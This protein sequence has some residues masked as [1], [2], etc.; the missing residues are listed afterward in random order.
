MR[1]R[2]IPHLAYTLA[3]SSALSSALA[4]QSSGITSGDLKG[5]VRIQGA[6][7]PLTSAVLTLVDPQTR[8]TRT[9]KTGQG[10]EYGFW[11]VPPGRYELTIEARGF[12]T[13]RFQN[14]EIHLRSVVVQDVELQREAEAYVEVVA[15]RAG[16]DPS[17]TQVATVIEPRYIEELP[18]DRRS[19][20]DF[21]LTVPGVII[22]NTPVNG[23]TPN[24]G[25]SIR[26]MNPRQNS[27]L[28]DGLD[29]NDRGMGAPRTALS[30]DAVQ[31]FQVVTAGFSAEFG[32][33]AGGVVNSITRSGTNNLAGSAFCYWRPGQMDA[34]SPQ[35]T[36][37]SDYRQRQFGA[38]VGGPLIPDK[39]FYLISAE[40]YRK[41]DLN[42]VVIPDRA[43][44]AIR[45]A[46][47]QVDG[48]GQTFEERQS[49]AFIRL[50]FLQSDASKW[51]LRLL[52]ARTKNENQIPWGGLT[53][54][55]AGG[56]VDLRD[57]TWMLSHQWLGEGSWI[58]EARFMY[59]S[60]DRSL[61]SMDAAH[62]VFVDI[63]GTAQFGTQRL[64]PQDT[65]AVYRQFTDT[66][67]QV[68]ERHTL[69]SGIDLLHSRNRGSVAQN[70]AG[71]Y[72]FTAIP[73]MGLPTSLD[74]FAAGVPAAFV[75]SFGNPSTSFQ[76]DSDAVFLQDD[77]QVRPSV[78]LK[79]GLRYDR[80]ILPTYDDAPAYQA[81]NTPPNSSDPVYGPTRLPDGEH[82][83]SQLYAVDRDWSR[84]RLSPRMAFS[85]QA[86]DD[87]RAYGGYGVYSGSTN[88]GALFGARLFN[89]QQVQTLFRTAYDPASEQPWISWANANNN[90]R[91]GQPPL[92]YR[93]TIVIPG[94]YGMPASRVWNLGL[95]WLPAQ[96]H[97]LYLDL[98]YSRGRGFMNTREVN[99][100]VPYYSP[101]LG[102][103]IPRRP[104]LRFGSIQRIDG[105]G[106]CRYRGQ[107]LG[108]QWRQEETWTLDLSYTH[109]QAEDNYSDWTTDYRVQNSF[110]PGSEWGP[111]SEDQTHQVLL[112]VA[113]A[114]PKTANHFWQNWVVSAIARYAS[115]RPYTRLLGY[116]ANLNGDG[117]SD[118]PSGVG[119][120]RE[121]TPDTC[122]VDLRLGRTCPFGR[123]R[124]EFLMEVFNLFN[125]SNVLEVQ[126][127]LGSTAPPYGTPLRYGGMRKFQVGVRMTF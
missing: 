91:Y 55:S 75:Q 28:L 38:R 101:A 16:L 59:A 107:T 120:N 82:P 25:L 44:G 11:M 114:S 51:G 56:T 9:R 58:N 115:G 30:Q 64:T 69:K 13:R 15:E 100:Y 103:V 87:V 94:S 73:Q 68:M 95:E 43:L 4:A 46:G 31:E 85:W 50:D 3:L 118:R 49:T 26:G 92:G 37:D 88:L 54:R 122:N 102:T 39:L 20:I 112:C 72:Q 47:F 104:D 96:G 79:L 2:T 7:E 22:S 77:W 90:H 19:F 23:G 98:V 127:N 74:A 1:S 57:T 99:A 110:D 53:A 21:S 84:S 93:P 106:E 14:L 60:R 81:L 78:L 40:G 61:Q 117:T 18:I 111:S 97:R 124:A 24:S 83:Y 36:E 12:L 108:W 76:A 65:G 71:I 63:L 52:E 109:S 121:T 34:R 119:R 89:D 17:R 116:D 86:K 62:T 123:S 6:Q 33:A 80:E 35:G 8:E 105:T 32:R 113:Y 45:A 10:G 42:T 70:F 48:G 67:T 29:N 126:N 125:R 27:F 66:F 41:S 5:Y